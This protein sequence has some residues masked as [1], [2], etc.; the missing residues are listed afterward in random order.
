M[1]Q[2]HREDRRG[3]KAGGLKHG[4]S[5]AKGEF[6]AIFDADFIPPVDFLL[7]MLPHFDHDFFLSLHARADR[8]RQ[9]ILSPTAAIFG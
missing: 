5:S 2:I 3:Y 4:L 8:T 7:R 1:V 9:P 6:I